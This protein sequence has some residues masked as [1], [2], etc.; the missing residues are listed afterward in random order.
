MTAHEALQTAG[1]RAAADRWALDRIVGPLAS[2]GWPWIGR[3][4]IAGSVRRC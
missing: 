3:F 1:E 4:R 2:D